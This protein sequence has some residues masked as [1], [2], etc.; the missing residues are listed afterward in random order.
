MLVI[1]KIGFLG[2][3]KVTCIPRVL[4]YIL[5]LS[6]HTSMLETSNIGGVMK[7][8]SV[9]YICANANID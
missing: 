6:F 3:S 8:M 7:S 5:I 9:N 4:R 1:I 2:S